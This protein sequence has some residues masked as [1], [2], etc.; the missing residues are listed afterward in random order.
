MII[1]GVLQNVYDNIMCATIDAYAK[2]WLIKLTETVFYYRPK[3]KKLI[4]Q[5]SSSDRKKYI[6]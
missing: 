2:R 4:E 5:T 6:H 1:S 3:E